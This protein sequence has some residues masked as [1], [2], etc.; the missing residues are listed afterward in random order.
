MEKDA[1]SCQL[2][3]T[4]SI[5]NFDF[6]DHNIGSFL[7]DNEVVPKKRYEVNKAKELGCWDKYNT[8]YCKLYSKKFDKLFPA[9]CCFCDD[10]LDKCFVLCKSCGPLSLFCHGCA[11]RVHKSA[12]FHCM[13]E[14]N[15]SIHA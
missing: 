10:E 6:E 5:N 7:L 9:H 14:I 3:S 11:I 12:L 15:V 4:S 2:S 1:A 8:D 13:V